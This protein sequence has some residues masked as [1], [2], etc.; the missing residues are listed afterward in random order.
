M[1]LPEALSLFFRSQYVA[2]KC[3][4]ESGQNAKKP[5]VLFIKSH[6]GFITPLK[7]TLLARH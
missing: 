3:P 7:G 2:S 1:W 6:I 4:P 5:L